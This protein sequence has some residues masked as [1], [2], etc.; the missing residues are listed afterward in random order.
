LIDQTAMNE[1][2]H[3][4]GADAKRAVA[5]AR[6]S[7]C[8]DSALLENIGGRKDDLPKLVPLKGQQ[9]RKNQFL[10]GT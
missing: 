6:T 5:P 2:L 4:E 9:S 10:I 8:R 7:R 3:N 1:P